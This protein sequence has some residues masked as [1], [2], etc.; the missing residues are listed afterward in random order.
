MPSAFA[1]TGG[2]E[3]MRMPTFADPTP[4]AGEAS[5]KMEFIGVNF[6]EIYHRKGLIIG[7]AF[8]HWH[9]AAR[10]RWSP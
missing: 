4:S 10:E 6:I 5:V 8:Q 7:L 2:A 3:V 1:T 9:R